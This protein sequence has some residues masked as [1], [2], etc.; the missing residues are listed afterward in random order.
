M[1]G[2]GLGSGR[3]VGGGATATVEGE[4]SGVVGRSPVGVCLASSFRGVLEEP[5]RDNDASQE[6]GCGAGA[7]MSA[8]EGL[9]T[10]ASGAG[11]PVV[12]SV[13]EDEKTGCGSP[14]SVRGGCV[15]VVACVSGSSTVTDAVLT[16]VSLGMLIGWRSVTADARGEAA[17]GSAT[18]KE[19]EVGALFFREVRQGRDERGVDVIPVGNVAVGLLRVTVSGPGQIG[20]AHV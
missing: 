3:S 15:S 10:L 8:S 17:S 5:R 4:G 2:A 16:S 9:A 20:R 7:G 1:A 6:R 11:K 14:L 18:I 19:R 12:S 13:G